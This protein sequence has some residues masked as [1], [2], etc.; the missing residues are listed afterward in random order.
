MYLHC[1]Y[2]QAVRILL[3]PSKNAFCAFFVFLLKLFPEKKIVGEA[4]YIKAS[5]E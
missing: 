2:D 3:L 4:K 1:T 5:K